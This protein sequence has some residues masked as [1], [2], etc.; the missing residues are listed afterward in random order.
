MASLNMQTI[1]YINLLDR[2]S[3][4]KTSK[5]FTYNNNIL[6]AVPK[7]MVSRAIGPN[8]INIRRMQESLGKRI[9]IIAEADGIGD[10]ERFIRSIVEPI[11]FKGIEIRDGELV[12]NAGG[13]Q[14]KA[15]LMGREKKRMEELAQIIKDTFSLELKIV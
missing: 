15:G 5:C 3:N 11:N 1:R 13:T 8:A 4:V 14:S 12:I 10:A 6:F 2:T 7:S 9:R